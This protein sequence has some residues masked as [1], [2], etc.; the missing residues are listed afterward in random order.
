MHMRTALR[1]GEVRINTWT[2]L[3]WTGALGV[4]TFLRQ[5]IFDWTRPPVWAWWCAYIGFPVA[6]AWVL[7]T[8]RGVTL[9][10]EGQALARAARAYFLVQGLVFTALSAALFAAPALMQAAWPWPL[11]PVL[12][13]IYSAPLLGMGLSSFLAARART[14]SEVRVFAYAVGVFAVCTLAA[15][16]VHR[17]VFRFPFASTYLWFA[18]LV[19][20]AV[21]IGALAGVPAWRTNTARGPSAR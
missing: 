4:V 17:A 13:Q 9:V 16:V 15:S 14:W 11:P 20:V 21:I 2:I 10:A 18:G 7:R 6:A 8:H 19:L 5:D 3:F 1:W 12:S